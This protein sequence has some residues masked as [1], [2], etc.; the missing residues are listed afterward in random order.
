MPQLKV[1]PKSIVTCSGVVSVLVFANRVFI[2]FIMMFVYPLISNKSEKNLFV[3]FYFTGALVLTVQRCCI[4]LL[5]TEG[6]ATC[7]GI[8]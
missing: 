1:N 2:W 5:I 6:V 4:Q 7:G 3:V 8:S